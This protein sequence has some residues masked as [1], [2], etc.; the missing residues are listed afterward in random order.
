MKKRIFKSIVNCAGFNSSLKLLILTGLFIVIIL[1]G[2][3]PKSNKTNI[4]FSSWGSE[5]EI[6]IIKP[7]LTEFETKNTDI[8]VE[9]IHIP[10]NYF[11]KLHL[12]VAS[13]LTPDVVFINNLNGPLYAEN[14]IFLDLSGY[15]KKETLVNCHCEEQSDEAIQ[16][17]ALSSWI[18]TSPFFFDNQSKKWVPSLVARNDEKGH[19]LIA[20]DFFP[21]ALEAFKYKGALYAIPRDISNLVVYYNKDIFDQ[22]NVQY[23]AEN[24]S[25]DEFL[26]TCRKL[27]KNSENN[28]AVSFEEAPLFWLPYL[29]S[30]GGGLISK[31]LDSIIINKPQ[32]IEALQFYADLRNKYHAAPTKSEAGSATMAQLFIQGKIAMHISGRWSTPRYRKDIHFNWDIA[33]FPR[34]KAG[35]IVDC[36][37]SG[38]AISSYS[39]HPKEAWRLIKFLANKKSAERFTQSGLIV[40]ARVDVANSEVFLNKNMPPKNSKVFVDIIPDSMPTPV[41]GN[42]QEITDILNTALE[43][44]WNGKKTAKEVVDKD[45]ILQLNQKLKK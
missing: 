9:F 13:K 17:I 27:T 41:T 21:Q 39:K 1:T 44:L 3:V 45:L 8:K 28:F 14:N 19:V 11:Q 29:W 30:N 24:W 36:D 5:S 37:T 12:L 2:C 38:W 26:Q 10:K 23:P 6:A 7:L 34:G 25:F 40:P 32:S 43:P 22:Y 20:N 4:K 42:Y 35:S 33:K 16:N 15:L 31:N 18:A